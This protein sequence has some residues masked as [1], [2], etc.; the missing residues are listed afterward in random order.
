MIRLNPSELTLTPADVADTRRRM[1]RRQAASA[2]ATLP[3]RIHGPSRPPAFRARLKPG[4]LRARHES[5]TALDDA[6]VLRPQRAVL[7]SVDDSGDL[8]DSLTESSEALSS[9]LAP[10]PL[11]SHQTILDQSATATRLAGPL[12]ESELRLPFRPAHQ[13]RESSLVA[14]QGDTS[15]DSPS[16]SKRHLSPPRLGRARTNSSEPGNDDLPPTRH[17][18][19]TD[20]QVDSATSRQTP[21]RDQVHASHHHSTLAPYSLLGVGT[22]ISRFEEGITG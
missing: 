9:W 16:P 4:P 10:S 7:S 3:P 6:P 22:I 2:N 13:D 8:Q 1:E 14:S 11:L 18:A 19:S 17:H 12:S 20:G 5:S 15:E 21:R